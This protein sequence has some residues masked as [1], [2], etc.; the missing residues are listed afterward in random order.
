M[1]DEI[2]D[3]K[4]ISDAK[5]NNKINTVIDNVN[6]TPDFEGSEKDFVEHR[7]KRDNRKT[8]IGILDEIIEHK[9][10]APKKDSE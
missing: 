1:Y 4:K 5:S 7:L 2:E 6:K 3:I 8:T 10:K 9:N